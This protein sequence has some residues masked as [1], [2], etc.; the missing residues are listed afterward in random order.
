SGNKI[1]N[2]YEVLDELGRGVHGKVKLGRN[3]I[4]GDHI[5]IKMIPRAA[6]RKR[7]GKNDSHEEKIRREVAILKKVRHPNVVSLLEVIDDPKAKKVYLILELV[8]LGEVNWRTRG[9][10]EITLTRS[11][12]R[13]TVLGLEY[14][15]YQGVVHRDIKPANLLCTSD[16]RVKISDFGVSYLGRIPK[17]ENDGYHS[18]SDYQDDE[19]M[20]LDNPVELA[21]TVGSPAYFAP[22]LCDLDPDPTAEAPQVTQAIDIWALGVTLY[23]LVYGRLPFYTEGS[24]FHLMRVI[25]DVPAYIPRRRLKADVDDDLHDLLTRLLEK[26]PRK[27]ITLREVKRHPWVVRDIEDKVAWLDETEP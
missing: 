14:L 12:I 15:H 11:A 10:R 17:D 6:K 24:E 19:D 20:D 4:T 16:H 13:D 2:D 23:G 21:K 3:L 5:A 18:E 7:L 22:E 27:R 9:A 1:I 25:H 8:E 26:D